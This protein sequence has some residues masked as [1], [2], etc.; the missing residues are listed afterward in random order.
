MKEKTGEK[1]FLERQ[2]ESAKK[3]KNKNIGIGALNAVAGTG[4]LLYVYPKALE[5]NDSA[6]ATIGGIVTAVCYVGCGYCLSQHEDNKE[7]IKRVKDQAKE[8]NEPK[9]EFKRPRRLETR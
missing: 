2:L 1:N 6:I 8:T 9:K 3:T 5:M 4:S 7:R